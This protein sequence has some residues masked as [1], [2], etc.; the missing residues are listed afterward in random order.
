M[1]K[2][3]IIKN[4]TFA[5]EKIIL[6]QIDL[7]S[8]ILLINDDE[9]FE[10]EN[11]FQ[12]Y[13]QKFPLNIIIS[14]NNTINTKYSN[15]T[16]SYTSHTDYDDNLLNKL[17]EKQS[18]LEEKSHVLQKDEI[19]QNNFLLMDNCL[20][21]KDTMSRNFA[22][23]MYNHKFYKISPVVKMNEIKIFTRDLLK[24]FDYVILSK[25]E[26]N[27]MNIKNLYKACGAAF[28]NIEEFENVFNQ[29]TDNNNY[30]IIK[31][32][33]TIISLKNCVYWMENPKNKK[34]K[35]EE[36]ND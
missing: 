18:N 36:V 20:L 7:N 12:Q 10:F 11:I 5:I 6:D 26:K 17:L 19:Y 24:C 22:E 29:L 23:L 31:N 27:I 16:I 1:N 15:D 3:I 35:L 9:T 4:K 14:K 30:M 2:E 33:M 21:S 13:R 32:K 34:R 28:Q 8:S 25:T